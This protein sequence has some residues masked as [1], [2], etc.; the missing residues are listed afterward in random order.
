[1]PNKKFEPTDE[2]RRT[3]KRMV[4]HGIPL[5][6][7]AECI[8]VSYTTLRKRF[9]K[10]IATGSAEATDEIATTLYDKAMNGSI[11]AME[12]W[13]KHR[14]GKTWKPVQ[15][16]TY[17]PTIQE[18]RQHDE[19]LSMTEIIGS[20]FRPKQFTIDL[21]KDLDPEDDDHPDNFYHGTKHEDLSRLHK[22]LDNHCTCGCGK[23]GEC[24]NFDGRSHY[25]KNTG[26]PYFHKSEA[27]IPP[28]VIGYDSNGD[29]IED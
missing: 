20:P 15:N 28:K 4:A 16:L 10:E 21:G 24:D 2:Q 26:L 23:V 11:R 22:Q 14:G 7:I 25:D 5:R 3:V 13:L 27:P 19:Y 6:E 18:V 8:D 1:M 12:F 17:Q 29:R 9:K